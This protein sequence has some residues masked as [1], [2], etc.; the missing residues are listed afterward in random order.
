MLF[1]EEN[2]PNQGSNKTT[3]YTYGVFGLICLLTLALP[4]K[5][6][7]SNQIAK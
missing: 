1:L 4:S 5:S 2:K 7:K 6:Q 3:R